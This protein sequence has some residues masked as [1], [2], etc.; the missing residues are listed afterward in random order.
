MVYVTIDMNTYLTIEGL[1]ELFLGVKTLAFS[2]IF[3][4]FCGKNRVI[5]S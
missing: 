1:D 2:M 4:I 3:A 5:A